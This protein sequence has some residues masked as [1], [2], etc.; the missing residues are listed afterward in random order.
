M[1][2]RRH[3]PAAVACLIL[4]TIASGA[5][6]GATA[7]R[8]DAC[9]RAWRDVPGAAVGQG[10]LVSVAAT[11]ADDAWAVG[12]RDA[13]DLATGEPGVASTLIEHWDGASWSF[14]TSPGYAG[15]L[16]GATAVSP[17]D[18]WAVGRALEVGGSSA[19][20][21][22]WDGHTWSRASL[23]SGLDVAESVAAL[24]P[25]DA[26]LVADTET[27]DSDRATI[28]HWDGQ[29]WTASASFP[30]TWLI[31]IAAVAAEDVWAVGS[32][33]DG[34]AVALHWDGT[35]WTRTKLPVRAESETD[36]WL[37]TVTAAA[38]DD[39][40]AGGATEDEELLPPEDS[41]LLLH[42][43]GR[44]WTQVKGPDT[45]TGTVLTAAATPG[46]L[47]AFEQDL[48]AFSFPDEG[49]PGH[50]DER[51][52]QGW[53]SHPG[54][55]DRSVNELAAVPGTGSAW[56]VG[57][58]GAGETDNG[59]PA[60]AIPLIRR[61]DCWAG[62]TATTS[63]DAAGWE[64]P[65]V[66]FSARGTTLVTSAAAWDGTTGLSRVRFTAEGASAVSPDGKLVADGTGGSLTI[67][68]VVTGKVLHNR[69]AH[70]QP[71]ESVVFSPDGRLV[72]TASDD[73][74]ARI[75][76]VA[77]GRILH[78]LAGHEFAVTGVRFSADSRS[79]LT[80]SGDGTARVWDVATGRVRAAISGQAEIR[81]AAFSPNGKLVATAGSDWTVL[82][83]D[84]ATGAA[85][86]SLAG[87][88]G[89]VWSV[90]FSADGA[91]VLTASADGTARVWDT[92]T[93]AQL[94]VL[95][96]PSGPVRSAAF[97]RT[98][99]RIVTA[100]DAG[101]VRIW[102]AAGPRL[103]RTVQTGLGSLANAD[104]S[105]D[106]RRVAAAGSDGDAGIWSVA[107]GRRI[108]FL[109]EA[110]EVGD[111]EFSADSKHIVTASSDQTARVWSTAT[112]RR[113]LVLAGHTAQL[114]SSAFS[115]DGR[116]VLTAARD[117]TARIWSA[118]T[119]KTLHILRGA[120]RPTFAPAGSTILALSPKSVAE[121]WS[122]R[123]GRRLL[124]LPGGRVDDAQFTPDGRRVVTR[125]A[126]TL[127]IRSARTGR[128]LHTLHVANADAYA[129][130]RNGSRMAVATSWGSGPVRVFD[131]ATG[132][133]LAGLAAKDEADDA[134]MS[135]NGSY[136][137]TLSSKSLT[138]WSV[139]T[140][141]P[142][143]SFAAPALI[144][145]AAFSPDGSRL[146]ASG[147]GPTAA[148]WDVATGRRLHVLHGRRGS[149]GA[150]SFSPNGREVLTLDQDGTAS[151]WNA[152]TG[153]LLHVLS[154]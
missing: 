11:S 46:D 13:F 54:E 19:L 73:L 3:A 124:A 120:T 79:A 90:A 121:V 22:G 64:P 5:G 131:V 14:D 62:A 42:W 116:L 34:D 75:V 152:A 147:D 143:R 93:G 86:H 24:A 52:A 61:L 81:D 43:N 67:R 84:A 74:T 148:I 94:A 125:R 150:V 112:G 129:F 141:K 68:S 20:A 134:L 130:D 98:G 103:L 83:S 25:D 149:I 96:N 108:A 78:T 37:D 38:P 36:Y 58:V 40:W 56:A 145:A 15:R 146:V 115:H 102:E 31:D 105:P 110:L 89:E 133:P 7:G 114:D 4:A 2:F 100:D 59:F 35:G 53:T 6:A 47:L 21:L 33:D 119:G 66:R 140:Q 32:N 1:T 139:A 117:A 69:A 87:H 92:A 29:H 99:S 104:L 109:P 151:V 135:P 128:L 27:A 17:T 101:F 18:A 77:S 107:D 44:A 23:P 91:R 12:E 122:A 80:F 71:I 63:R 76:D 127:W 118:R 153:R 50:L 51:D 132:R 97:N 95:A 126:S 136:V 137:L 48:N 70:S 8:S 82:L 142:V 16:L 28:L 138:L 65:S 26:W 45:Y 60:V 144:D 113:Q 55:W 85:V 57:F 30:A 9:L 49:D 106:G 39:V 72:A 88:G 123:T 41:E 154:Q 111:A 10:Q